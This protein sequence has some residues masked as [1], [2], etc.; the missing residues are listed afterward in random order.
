MIVEAIQTVVDGR[1]LTR[2]QAGE[3]MEE[4]LSGGVSPAQFGALL[5][6]LRLKG[7]TVEEIAGFGE[8]MRR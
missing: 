6:A 3:V 1:S 7:E 2:E 4:I 8:T 5:T